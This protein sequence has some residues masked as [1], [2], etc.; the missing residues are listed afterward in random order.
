MAL[1]GGEVRFNCRNNDS[2]I[3]VNWMRTTNE[4]KDTDVF[5]VNL[6]KKVFED[7]MRVERN[8]D[9]LQFDLIIWNVLS[10][11]AG[12]YSCIDEAGEGE[13]KSAELVVL[14]LFRLSDCVTVSR[15]YV[16]L[17]HVVYIRLCHV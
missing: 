1:I 2:S 13:R 8:N 5:L 14:G 3:P 6:T 4:G 12:I 9:P 10:T 16:R 15:I 11:D 7:R 17:W